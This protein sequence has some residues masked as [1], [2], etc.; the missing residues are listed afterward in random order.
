MEYATPCRSPC[1]S[2]GFSA[3]EP[4]QR[5]G[6]RAAGHR[7]SRVYHGSEEAGLQASL[8]LFVRREPFLY[9]MQI[10]G[11][12]S[13]GTLFADTFSPHNLY[14]LP[15]AVHRYHSYRPDT[16]GLK[17]LSTGRAT[18]TME[19][20]DPDG[21]LLPGF[22]STRSKIVPVEIN[23]TEEMGRWAVQVPASDSGPQSRCIA[24]R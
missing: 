11:N 21:F 12:D 7:S 9:R 3:C 15:T 4:Q 14:C 13:I 10:N 5:H 1:D 24:P 19:R 23:L 22:F 20:H 2:V 8:G 6:H 17:S 18:V 16:A